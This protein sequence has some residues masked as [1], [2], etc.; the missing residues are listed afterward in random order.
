M[1]NGLPFSA[2]KPPPSSSLSLGAA[3]L[4]RI[5]DKASRS[6]LPAPPLLCRLFGSALSA[7]LLCPWV[8]YDRSTHLQVCGSSIAPPTRRLHPLLCAHRMELIIAANLDLRRRLLCS[9][10][11]SSTTDPARRPELVIVATSTPPDLRCSV[12]V[13]SSPSRTRQLPL[14]RRAPT[15]CCSFTYSAARYY[16]FPCHLLQLLML[17]LLSYC[18]CTATW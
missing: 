9:A 3:P 12:A 10:R 4:L 5:C 6:A 18:Y 1:P 16:S 14:L 7:P 8:L 15:Y 2:D 17:L 13:A 11:G